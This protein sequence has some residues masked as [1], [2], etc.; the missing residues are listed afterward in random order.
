[1][2]YNQLLEILPGVVRSNGKPRISSNN[3]S[4]TCPVCNK[5]GHAFINIKTYAWDCKKCNESGNL[6]GLLKHLGLLHLLEGT[7]VVY[8]KLKPL[9]KENI[10]IE[11]KDLQIADKSLPPGFKRLGHKDNSIYSNYLRK[12]KFQGVDFNILQPGYTELI[13]RYEDYVIIPIERDFSVKGFVARYI[14]NDETKKRYQNSVHTEF[15]KLLGLYDQITIDTRFLILVE[16]IFDA[17]SVIT[18]LELH[19][20]HADMW[21]CCTFGK[22][23]SHAQIE[24]IKKTKVKFLYLLYDARDAVDD[25]KRA[26]SAARRE[27]FAVFGCFSNSEHDPGEM[28]SREILECLKLAEPIERFQISKIQARKLR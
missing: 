7:P 12:R 4:F 5:P 3:I 27:G 13:S 25:I 24:L 15:S 19:E 22:R 6:Y 10:S 1:M 2:D 14:G 16:G 21:C 8:D 11:E 28:S 18:E 20:L 23:L 9:E 26:G 17:I